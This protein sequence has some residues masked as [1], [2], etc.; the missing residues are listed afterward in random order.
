M[1]PALRTGLL[2]TAATTPVFVLLALGLAWLSPRL[3]WAGPEAPVRR[4]LPRLAVAEDSPQKGAAWAESAALLGPAP[5]F[6]PTPLN[7]SQVEPPLTLRREPG[8]QTATFSPRLWHT[9]AAL[10]L[11]TPSPFPEVRT[12]GVALELGRTA[13]P[14]SSL[15]ERPAVLANPLPRRVLRLEAARTPG[16]DVVWAQEVGEG[17]GPLAKPAGEWRPMEF[18]LAVGP[19]GAGGEPVLVQGSGL[20]EWDQAVQDWLLRQ[21][22]LDLRLWPGLYAI[23]V[24]P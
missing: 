23:R 24:G 4:V 9:D 6:L 15:G 2:W 16:G 14:W 13:N 8:E 17:G 3:R 11:E 7:G 10:T 5:L 20:A 21:S 18:I 19:E 22:R 1:T 12:P